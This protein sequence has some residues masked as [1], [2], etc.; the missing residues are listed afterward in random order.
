MTRTRTARI[1]LALMLGIGGSGLASAHPFGVQHAKVGLSNRVEQPVMNQGRFSRASAAR[2]AHARYGGRVLSIR[3]CQRHARSCFVV[4]LLDH[5]D[6]RLV[7]VKPGR[8]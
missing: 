2:R 8:D 5:G 1:A 7:H 6:V 3:H 4:Q